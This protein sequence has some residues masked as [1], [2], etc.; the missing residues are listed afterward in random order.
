[1]GSHEYP[2]DIE[3]RFVGGP[4][5]GNTHSTKSPDSEW[6]RGV[7]HVTEEGKE[8]NRFALDISETDKKG[9]QRAHYEIERRHT[10]RKG[11]AVVLYC[12]F[13]QPQNANS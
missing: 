2:D 1:V 13:V 4:V 6:I 12:R 10:L 3:L 11:G 9:P 8:G 7:F 5:G